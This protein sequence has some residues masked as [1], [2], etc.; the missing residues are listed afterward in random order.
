M[1]EPARQL[2]AVREANRDM[3]AVAT[4]ALEWVKVSEARVA[5]AEA[6]AETVRGELKER[7]MKTLR[8]M[9]AQA[10]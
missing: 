5:A 8:E 3:H 6:A 1:S 7:A 2:K 10:R 4:Q 9:S